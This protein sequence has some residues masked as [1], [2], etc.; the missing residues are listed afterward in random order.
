ME[1]LRYSCFTKR[2]DLILRKT[3][4]ITMTEMASAYANIL[5]KR[6]DEDNL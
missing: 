5:L 3:E 4:V 1:H 2:I 6:L